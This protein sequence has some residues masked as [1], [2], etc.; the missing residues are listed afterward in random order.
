MTIKHFSFL[1]LLFFLNNNAMLPWEDPDFNSQ[2]NK[3]KGK[4]K[5]NKLSQ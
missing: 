2:E 3:I 4:L 1:S 5:K